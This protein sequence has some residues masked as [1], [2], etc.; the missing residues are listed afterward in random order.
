[1]ARTCTAPPHHLLPH[2]PHI[3]GFAGE[4]DLDQ[5]LG[6]MNAPGGRGG[7]KG[8]GPKGGGPKGGGAKGGRRPGERMR[9]GM[10]EANS[11]RQAKNEKFGFGGRK[12]LGKQNDASSAADMSGYK[13]GRFD[14]GLGARGGVRKGGKGG[15][16]K[17]GA[18]GK[19]GGK[20]QRPGK[21]RRQQKS[22]GGKG[23]G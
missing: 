4:L 16:A 8:G 18:G 11:K 15:G 20:P 5:E 7:P 6:A 1:M 3:Q 21:A 13:P 17:G 2:P 22:K 12:R 19:K 10:P 14:D 9:P 23:R